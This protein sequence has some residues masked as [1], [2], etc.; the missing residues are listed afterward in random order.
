MT[1]IVAMTKNEEKKEIELRVL[2]AARKAGAP[3]PNGELGGEEPDF[4]F[5]TLSGELGIEIS[6]VLR[7]ASSNDGILPAEAEAFHQSIMLAAQERYQKTD[8]ASPARV[9]VYFS[10]ARGKRQDKR[11]LIKSL[12]ECIAAN[13]Y[14]ANPAVVLKGNELPEGF[15]HVL[16]TGDEPGEWW[17]GECGGI[18]L[19]EIPI[20]LAAKIAAKNKLL[21]TYR[22]NLPTG[23]Q[24]WLLL[25]SRVT[26]ARSIPIPHGM[27][28]WKFAFEFDRVFWFACLENKVIDIQR[29]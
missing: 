19:S 21:P 7:P 14:R 9:S 8:A 2:D 12:V 16:I 10:P 3:I 6:E 1:S 28:E 11:Q 23:A 18:T 27:E 17:C 13:R 22:A 29:A 5:R 20:E 15:D 25:Y 24:I 4:T 26:V